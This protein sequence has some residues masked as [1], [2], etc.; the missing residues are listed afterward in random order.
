LEAQRRELK[1]EESVTFT[2]FVSNDDLV[3][4][5]NASAALV[6]PSFNEGFGL[7][8]VEAMACGLAVAASR[9]GSLP[10]VLGD[11]GVYFSPADTDE[12]ARVLGELLADS[13]LRGELATRGLQR[14]GQFN[15]TTAARQT[16]ELF[17]EMIGGVSQT[18]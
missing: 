10:E 7:P 3:G 5:Y 13:R 15:W 9:A 14:A 2:G 12:M 11:A 18:A 6:L 17:E 8:V 16:V 4:L 1:L